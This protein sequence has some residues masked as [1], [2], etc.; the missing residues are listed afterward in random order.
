MELMQE[1]SILSSF[2]SHSAWQ[3]DVNATTRHVQF[4]IVHIDAYRTF[5]ARLQCKVNLD[6]VCRGTLMFSAVNNEELQ[7]PHVSH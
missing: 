6:P 3:E 4:H 5:Q 2:V 7:Y 1:N